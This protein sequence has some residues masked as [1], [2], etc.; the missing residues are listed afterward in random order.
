MNVL[1]ARGVRKS[2]GANE[3]VS[4]VDLR[5]ASGECFGLLG[6]NG[7]GKTTTLKLCLGLIRPNAGEIELLGDALLP[8]INPVLDEKYGLQLATFVVENVSVPAEVEQAIDSHPAVLESAVIPIPDDKWG[9]VPKA[10]VTLKP[11]TSLSAE[12]LVE[13]V[14]G[15][16]ARYKVPKAIEFGDLPKTTTGKIQKFVLRDKEWA[17]R[18]RRIQ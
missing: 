9:E 10:F 16:I 3:V 11:D 14:R 15:R 8:L 1:S 17:G 2:Y 4:G 6:P 13:Y 5:V 7:A 12:E 18:E